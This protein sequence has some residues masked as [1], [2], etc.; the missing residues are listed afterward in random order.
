M[1]H[2]YFGKEISEAE[3]PRLSEK[4]GFG[5]KRRARLI[6]DVEENTAVFKQ[7][8]TYCCINQTIPFFGF[9][10]CTKQS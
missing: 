5:G 6:I 10:Y 7:T 2:F 8:F 3:M 1:E 9:P 4:I